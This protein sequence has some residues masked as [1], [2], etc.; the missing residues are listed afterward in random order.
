MARY[1]IMQN[2]ENTESAI[3]IRDGF[4]V[5]A[6]IVPQFWL[7]F[8]RQWLAASAVIAVMVLGALAAWQFNQPLLAL[9][10]DLP[11]SIYVALEGASLRIANLT[12]EGWHEA[13]VVEADNAEEAEIRFYGALPQTAAHFVSV[14]PTMNTFGGTNAFAFPAKN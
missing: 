2:G 8:H 6:L 9:A 11:L 1:V 12:R 5:P 13:K 14:A 10:A 7:L 4:S 3:F